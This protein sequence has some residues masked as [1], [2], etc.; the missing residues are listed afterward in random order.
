MSGGKAKKTCEKKKSGLV[1][2]FCLF[3]LSVNLVFAGLFSGCGAKPQETPE[4]KPAP[5]PERANA[6]LL[7]PDILIPGSPAIAV[8]GNNRAIID[9]SNMQD[10]YVTARSL[11]SESM[12][13]KVLI[14]G[15]GNVR[16]SYDLSPGGG[17][18]VFPLNDGN[19]E[20]KIGVYEQIEG[21]K[22]ASV[23]ATVLDVTLTDEFAPFI[24][25]NQ[26]VNYE[27]NSTAVRKAAELIQGS[28]SLIAKITAVFNYVINNIAYDAE[29]AQNV[30]SGYLPDIDAVLERGMGICFDYS[31]LMTAMLRSRGVPTKLV[32]GY[33][34]EAYHAWISVYAEEQGWIESVIFF[35][36]DDWTLMDPT[37]AASGSIR[38]ALNFIGDGTNYR[39]IYQ[40]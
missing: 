9:Y 10:G 35:E 29:L 39:A 37:F 18:E 20:Y 33:A 17:Y 16:Y 38:A 30:Q 12:R 36:G 21:D 4:I 28:N 24:R 1:T 2:R 15:P 6:E 14:T 34:G 3:V 32:I 22:Y 7:I 5:Q 26:F 13:L 23:V 19:G 31:A 11:E 8:E 25:P 27:R 40:H